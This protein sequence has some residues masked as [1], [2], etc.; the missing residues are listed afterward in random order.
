MKKILLFGHWVSMDYYRKHIVLDGGFRR[1]LDPADRAER[2]AIMRV[3]RQY[4]PC[5][6]DFILSQ[7]EAEDY[8]RKY[9]EIPRY[10]GHTREGGIYENPK[11]W[12]G[13][14]PNCNGD[15]FDHFR[16]AKDAEHREERRKNRIE[17][18]GAFCGRGNAKGQL[19]ALGIIA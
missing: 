19:A 1:P 4:S 12:V 6:S 10:I 2:R 15:F 7:K 5:R 18:S 17:L 14:T 11:F 8:V 3:L 9:R 13:R 16:A